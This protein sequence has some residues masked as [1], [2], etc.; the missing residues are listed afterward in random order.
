[1][2]KLTPRE[3]D[4]VDTAPI[5][6]TTNV[7]VN[8]T[9]EE[10]WAVLIDNERWPEWFAAAKACRSTSDEPQGVG[11]TRWIHVDLF[12]VNERFVAWDPPHRWAFTILDVNLPGVISVVE[13]ALIEPTSDGK[14]T[15]SY[16]MAS[17]VAPY[18]RPLVPL[19]R[20]RL[21]GMF[22]KGLAGIERQVASL[23]T[24]AA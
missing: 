6:I 2:P 24:M 14:T 5:K 16:T 20:W 19:L 10:V 7:T 12:K 11:S 1:M 4:F 17:E 8:G 23:R 18:L 3:V 22:V 13:R 21:S 15:V 9:P